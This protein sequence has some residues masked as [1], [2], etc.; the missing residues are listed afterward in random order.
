MLNKKPFA[1]VMAVGA[2]LI[3]A[4]LVT[5]A[6]PQ[7]ERAADQL[8]AEKLELLKKEEEHRKLGTPAPKS[9]DTSLKP[10]QAEEW[11]TGIRDDIPAPFRASELMIN[12]AWQQDF[13]GNHVQVYAG[14]ITEDAEQGLVV[15]RTTDVN[16][17]EQVT[18]ERFPTP[19]KAGS[20]TVVAEKNHK[21]TLQAANGTTFEFDVNKKEYTQK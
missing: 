2:F 6:T 17:M 10:V 1:L 12:N 4:T 8:P 20:L 13:G 14:H 21:L 7:N 15:I 3:G 19:V 5:S 18:V 11:P 9:P 16:D